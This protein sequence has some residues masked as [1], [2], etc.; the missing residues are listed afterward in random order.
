[1]MV[2]AEALAA[3]HAL[4]EG[5]HYNTLHSVA[6]ELMEAGY[7]FDSW[8]ELG[9]TEAGRIYLRRG[10]RRNIP[11]SSD[12]EHVYDMSVHMMQVPKVPI[13]RRPSKF[14]KNSAPHHVD[15]GDYDPTVALDTT[16]VATRPL[17]LI[18]EAPAQPLPAAE[19][20]L[21][22]MLRAAG[23]ASG[24]TGVWVKDEWVEE[25]FNALDGVF[26]APEKDK[27]NTL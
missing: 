18:D 15:R 14:W 8:G 4:E 13:D 12:D 17:E 11:I 5:A 2:S 1:M 21:Q 23:V 10:H 25:F 9:M 3:L 24:K 19:S 22:K 16:A 6:R 26:S 27:G 20:Q 7:A